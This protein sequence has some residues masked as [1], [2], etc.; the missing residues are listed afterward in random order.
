MCRATP[1]K[2]ECESN[3]SRK[4]ERV[5]M[6]AKKA[7]KPASAKAKQVA[8]DSVRLALFAPGM[9]PMHRA[10]LGG[11]ACVL[12]ALEN[13]FHEGRLKPP[14]LPGDW[15][16]GCPPWTVSETE[17]E[18]RFGQPKQAAQFLQRLFEYAFAI[19]S[20]GLIDLPGCFPGPP[21]AAAL[22]DQQQGFMLT[23]LQHGKVRDVDKDPTLVHYD[24]SDG[25]TAGIEV[26]YRACRS[27][28]RQKGWE[29]FVDSHG[30]FR[31]TS[32]RVDGPLFPGA[33]VRHVAFPSH[34]A[35]EEPA[36][37]V[38]CL[39]FA[40]LGTLSLAVN[41]G[42]GILVIPEVDNL[43]DF[44]VA[45]PLMS[46]TD[47]L[48]WKVANAADAAL[49][50]LVR[51]RMR[52][53]RDAGLMPGCAAVTFQTTPW[54]KQL[55]SRVAALEV[56]SHDPKQLERFE[57]A[58]QLLPPRIVMTGV[59]SSAAAGKKKRKKAES[60]PRTFRADSVV[61][62]LVAEN[63]ALGR[64]W[65]Q[66]FA[67]LMYRKNPANDKPYR[68]AVVHERK[69]LFAMI[70]E[71]AMW[72]RAGDQL[73]VKAVHEA[74]RL[75]MGRIRHDTDGPGTKPLSQATKNR[76]ERFREKLRL[77]LCG[78]KTAAQVRFVLTDLFSRGGSNV[79]LRE[80]WQHVLPVLQHDWQLARDLGLLALASYVGRGEADSGDSSNS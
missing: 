55:K 80:S 23:F 61:R 34:T 54:A 9:T 10:G 7:A 3:Y 53:L 28:N 56:E 69:G 75:S 47:A 11:L 59:E 5:D 58:L 19:R 24:S 15:K 22:A 43:L 8:V 65:Y 46:P 39:Y 42:V 51:V 45:R 63:L 57:I 2:T 30:C 66:D 68:E 77:D 50:S 29:E 32:A 72:D 33:V 26:E 74:M 35:V 14:Q 67:R 6:S 17:I 49:Q 60:P 36:E 48:G 71:N 1:N 44:I 64:P 21:T 76:W 40:M 25:Q 27:F 12:H 79:V 70:T 62:P 52:N 37:R 16:D 13:D 31:S 38:V 41:R 4:A 18:L 73:V 20:D 78:A